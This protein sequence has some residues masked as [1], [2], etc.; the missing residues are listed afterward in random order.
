MNLT[1]Y[2]DQGEQILYCIVPGKEA[3]GVSMEEHG[4]SL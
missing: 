2:A 4:A 3:N 1:D